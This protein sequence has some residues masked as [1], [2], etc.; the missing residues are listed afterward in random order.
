MCSKLGQAV[1]NTINSGFKSAEA[2]HRNWKSCR[3]VQSNS[4]I[5]SVWTTVITTIVWN[6]SVENTIGSALYVCRDRARTPVSWVSDLLDYGQRKWSSRK[7][8]VPLKKLSQRW[9]SHHSLPHFLQHHQNGLQS[10]PIDICISQ[11]HFIVLHRHAK[12]SEY[13]GIVKFE[14][15]FIRSINWYLFYLRIGWKN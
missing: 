10:S 3:T 7:Y 14:Q 5:S 1:P 15:N 13:C 2:E 8:R 11:T 9:K 4:T 12:E 6:W